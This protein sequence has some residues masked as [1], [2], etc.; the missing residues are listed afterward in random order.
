MLAERAA[1]AP[2]V[3]WRDRFSTRRLYRV[4]FNTVVPSAIRAFRRAYPDVE[5]MLEEADTI[6][7]IAGLQEGSLDA[8]LLPP[9]AAGRETLSLR[10]PIRGADDDCSAETPPRAHSRHDPQGQRGLEDSCWPSRPA[11]QDRMSRLRAVPLLVCFRRQASI[12]VGHR[13]FGGLMRHARAARWNVT[14][15]CSS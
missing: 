13:A 3:A 1:R 10:G 7:L 8:A 4:A 12:A 5:L 9:R 14:Q 6:P 11:L 15:N 2:Q